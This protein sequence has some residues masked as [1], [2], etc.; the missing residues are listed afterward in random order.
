MISSPPPTK[1]LPFGGFPPP[2][3][4]AASSSPA[5]GGPIRGS[6]VPRLPA[7]T[8]GLSQLATPFLGARAEPSTGRRGCRRTLGRGPLS[9]P[10]RARSHAPGNIRNGA[11]MGGSLAASWTP[12]RPE[13]RA[14]G[15]SGDAPA[16]PRPG[17]LDAARR[18]FTRRWLSGWHACERRSYGA[19]GRAFKRNS[20]RL[21]AALPAAP[22]ALHPRAHGSRAASTP[23]C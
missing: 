21:S 20:L 7:P 23:T 11:P 13:G 18:R 16:P 19:A 4:G 5:A 1:M 12:R 22:R 8:P 10:Q 9:K 3:G 15:V 14:G 17:V 2:T 6:R